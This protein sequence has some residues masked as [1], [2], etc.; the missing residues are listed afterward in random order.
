[1][2]PEEARTKQSPH[3]QYIYV[4]SS[5]RYVLEYS[6]IGYKNTGYRIACL[7]AIIHSI[8]VLD[9][10][11]N[12]QVL[13]TCMSGIYTAPQYATVYSKYKSINSALVY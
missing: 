4:Y 10:Y 9:M 7:Y 3:A 1:L 8:P 13:G 6:S 11:L 5:I 2:F 12:I